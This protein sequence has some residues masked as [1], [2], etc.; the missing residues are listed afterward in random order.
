MERIRRDGK[1][2]TEI[3]LRAVPAPGPMT[4]GAQTQAR[5]Q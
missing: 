1:L 4:E 3:D 2:D 5:P